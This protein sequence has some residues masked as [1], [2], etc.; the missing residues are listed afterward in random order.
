MKKIEAIIRPEQFQQ[1][2]TKL[3]EIGIDGLTVYEAAGCGKQRKKQGVFRGN[4]FELQLEPKVKV[5]MVIRK[6]L[7]EQTIQ[8]IIEACSTGQVGDGKIFV[9]DI[10]DVYRIRTGENGTQ[11]II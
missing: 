1:L 6:S 7:Y 8:V 10:E 2:R 4:P 3:L 11:A 5:E 9:S